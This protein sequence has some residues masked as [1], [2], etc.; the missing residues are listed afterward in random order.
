MS[1]ARVMATEAPADLLNYSVYFL[2][3]RGR[4]RARQALRAPSDDC[5]LWM[6]KALE[7][8]HAAELWRQGRRIAAVEAPRSAG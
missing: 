2:D 5:A 3:V 7:F 1:H 4:V 8:G 6:L